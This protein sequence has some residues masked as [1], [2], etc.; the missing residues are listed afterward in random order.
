MFAWLNGPGKVFRDP[1][2]GSTNYLNAYTPDGKLV[3]VRQK[4]AKEEHEEREE[5]RE[6]AEGAEGENQ[7]EEGSYSPRILLSAND[8]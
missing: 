8:S 7:P 6:L 1:L 2:P 3:R 5:S 4:E